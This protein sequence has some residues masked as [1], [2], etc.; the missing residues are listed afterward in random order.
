MKIFCKTIALLLSIQ[1]TCLVSFGQTAVY[2][3]HQKPVFAAV[4]S[5]RRQG[6]PEE[7]LTRLLAY[8]LDN[9]LGAD[10]TVHILTILIR[11]REDRF[12]LSPFLDKIQ[13]GLAKRIDPQRLEDG[14]NKR[15]DDYRFVRQLLKTEYG[16]S[17]IYSETDLTDLVESLGFGIT[18]R[19]LRRLFTRVPGVAPEMLAVAAKNKA[20]LKQLGFDE[21]VIDDILLTGLMNNS[22]TPQWA[23][24]FKVAAA[25]KRKGIPSVRIAEVAKNILLQKGDLEQVLMELEFTARD[26]RHGPHLDSPPG[27][28]EVN[29]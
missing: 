29:Q 14:L 16:G 19:E 25:A 20:L 17:R 15:L 8:A 26:V 27:A 22:L 3:G 24:F 9:Q 4:D 23:L 7:I 28:D 12:P 5:A 18:R 6:V 21:K 1:T 11:I 13:E 10:H 2:A